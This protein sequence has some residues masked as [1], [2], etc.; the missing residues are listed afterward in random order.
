MHRNDSALVLVVVI[1]GDKPCRAALD[2]LKFVDVHCRGG[3]TE[4]YSTVDL[5][6][7]SNAVLLHDLGQ[8]S[9]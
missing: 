2:S 8:C 9:E 4:L 6:H 1:V 5:T 7:A 3:S